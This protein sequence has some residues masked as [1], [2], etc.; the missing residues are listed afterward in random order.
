MLFMLSV[1]HKPFRLSVIM[2]N[3]AMLNVVVPLEEQLKTLHS[4]SAQSH[5]CCY[6][7]FYSIAVAF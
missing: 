6:V 5:F 1:T 7:A 4:H 2:L 3:V